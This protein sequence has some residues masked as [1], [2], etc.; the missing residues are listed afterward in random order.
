MDKGIDD[1]QSQPESEGIPG[2]VV[3]M[4]VIGGL[5]ILGGIFLCVKS[6]PGEPPEGYSWESVA[7]TPAYIWLTSG[8]VSGTLFFAGGAALSY[9]HNINEGMAQVLDVLYANKEEE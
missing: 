9:L 6:W 1:S 5:T 2:I 8:L 7:Y 4:R 3:A